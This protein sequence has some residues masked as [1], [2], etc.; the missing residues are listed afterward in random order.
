M[1]IIMT[2]NSLTFVLDGRAILITDSSHE[3]IKTN[4]LGGKTRI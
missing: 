4:R 3:M 2:L 1:M